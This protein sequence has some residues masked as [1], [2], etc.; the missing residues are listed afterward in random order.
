MNLVDSVWLEPSPM[1]VPPKL[2]PNKLHTTQNI[3]PRPQAMHAYP[4]HCWTHQYYA[5]MSL[6]TFLWSSCCSQRLREHISWNAPPWPPVSPNK[7]CGWKIRQLKISRACG[8]T[9]IGEKRQ[10]FWF[11]TWHNGDGAMVSRWLCSLV[12]PIAASNRPDVSSI[13][14]MTR[15]DA[16]S[17]FINTICPF[18]HHFSC[19]TLGCSA[20]HPQP[21]PRRY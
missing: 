18:V 21:H 2:M 10:C 13:S 1:A 7:H 6:I 8:G 17:V 9:E 5:R 4:H 20:S 14:F 19:P 16:L 12:V 3:L 11:Y 15:L